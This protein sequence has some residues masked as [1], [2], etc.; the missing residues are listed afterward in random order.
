MH[1]QLFLE[2][3]ARDSQR[4]IKRTYVQAQL[5]RPTTPQ[6]S[7]WAMVWQPLRLWRSTLHSGL[8]SLRALCDLV[9]SGGLA[10]R[11]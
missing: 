2:T 10:K 9:L 1:T 4:D 8:G 11:V 5:M 7:T 3:V 6:L